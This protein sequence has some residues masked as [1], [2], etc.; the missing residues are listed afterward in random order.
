MF[1]FS[2]GLAVAT[3]VEEVLCVLSGDAEVESTGG[4]ENGLFQEKRQL[5]AEP[6]DRG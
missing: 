5:W 1:G 3:V 4:L 6:S 2:C